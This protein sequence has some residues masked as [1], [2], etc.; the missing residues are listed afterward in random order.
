MPQIDI[1]MELQR[2]SLERIRAGQGVQR[3]QLDFLKQKYGDVL[4]M[5]K[6]AL[7]TYGQ[8]PGARVPAEFGRNVALFQ[9]GGQF[10]AGTEAA[11]AK[12]QQQEIAAGNVASA[13][14]GLGSS[15]TAMARTNAATRS[16]RNARLL[17]N[18]ER[19]RLLSGAYG[20][21]GQAGLSARQI[22]AQRQNALL[23]ILG[24]LS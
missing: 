11:I 10:G 4:G 22:D 16:A 9:P 12:G 23:S 18:E 21:A 5:Y 6:T 14:S 3:D 2:Q 24:S 17:A 7:N 15:T 13:A 20:Q 19:M 8:G 1:G